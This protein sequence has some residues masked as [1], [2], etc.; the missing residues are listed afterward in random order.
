MRL[1][2]LHEIRRELLS[3]AA[4]SVTDEAFKWGLTELGRFARAY[5]GLFGEVPSETRRV[6]RHRWA[7]A[8]LLTP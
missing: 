1:R 7:R 3:G 5:S 2:T 6:G 4:E 8:G